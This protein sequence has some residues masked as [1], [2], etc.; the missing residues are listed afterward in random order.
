MKCLFV[1]Q[2]FPGQYRHLAAHLAADPRHQVV[3]I[4]QRSEGELPGVRKMVYRPHR[5][6][7]HSVHQYLRETETAVINAQSVA[8][9]A[10]DLK[11]AGFVPD[12][13]LSHNG[14][15]EIWYLK[16]V[17]PQS[18]LLGYFEFF[19]RLSGADVG[20][21]PNEPTAFDDGPRLRT[22]NLGNYLAL[23]TV[24]AGLC[25]THWQKSRYPT[26]YHDKLH[27][28]HDGI[29][30]SI[31]RPNPDAALSLAQAGLT[32]SRADE[33]VTYVARNL[34][35]YRGFPSFMRSLPAVLAARPQALIVIVGGDEVSYGKRL[36]PGQ[37]YRQ[38]LQAELGDA[39]DG[40]RVHFLG[41]VAYP[42]FLKILQLSRVH[43]YLTYPFVL[44]WSV[45]EAM[46]AG[47]LVVASNTAPVQEVI[48][49][50]DNGWL[51]D[52]FSPSEI[53][54]RVIEGL[55]A[56]PEGFAAMRHNARQTVIERYD[57]NTVCLP[58]QLG[59]LDRLRR[60]D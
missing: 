37:T 60:R 20:F 33:V 6:R 9:I 2:N 55:K 53:A 16:E 38:Q 1:H 31:V 48:C 44:S 18:P 5:A 12:L 7:S 51:V 3:F 47:C 36:P 8:R 15:G 14:W 10:L 45:L 58:A 4:T 22:K 43:V 21:D 34:E 28:I 41:K 39:L 40:R 27:V 35:P 24:D 11:R 49:D 13:M 30:T 50:G 23:D 57:L 25:P 59:W 42:T 29:D 56:G 54:E 32:L 52:F 19:Y 26:G 17:F 46:A